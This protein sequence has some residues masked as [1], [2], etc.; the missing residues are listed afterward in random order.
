MERK[1][2]KVHGILMRLQFSNTFFSVRDWCS[3]RVIPQLQIYLLCWFCI[4]VAI[5]FYF[6]FFNSDNIR[7]LYILKHTESKFSV[8]TL[9]VRLLRINLVFQCAVGG[10][11]QL[12]K[13]P[14][15]GIGMGEFCPQGSFLMSLDVRI[16]PHYV[17]S[18]TLNIQ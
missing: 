3:V 4:L 15:L 11:L 9:Q 18:V 10:L 6:Y 8:F 1:T 5:L 16:L 2:G 12:Y 13:C 17:A 7:S 14:L